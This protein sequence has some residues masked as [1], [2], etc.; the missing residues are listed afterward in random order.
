MAMPNPLPRSIAIVGGFW[1]TVFFLFSDEPLWLLVPAAGWSLGMALSGAIIGAAVVF[2]WKMLTLEA[3]DAMPPVRGM[4]ISIGTIPKQPSPPFYKDDFVVSWWRKLLP[5]K[6]ESIDLSE[7]IPDWENFAEQHPKHAALIQACAAM[8]LRSKLPAATVSGGHGGASLFQHSINVVRSILKLV[9][10]WRYEGHKNKNGEIVFPMI[11]SEKTHH[12]FECG[13]PLPVT[14]AF[15]HDIGKIACYKLQDD[16]SAKEVRGNHD[17]EGARLLRGIQELWNLPRE[18]A[19]ALIIAVGFYHHPGSLPISSWITDRMR[20][21]TELLSF[22]DIEAGIAEGRP[23][24]HAD[25]EVSEDIQHAE[26]LPYI[27]PE[28]Q[29]EDAARHE[30]QDEQIDQTTRGND[31]SIAQDEADLDDPRDLLISV[32][33]EPNRVNGKNSMKRVAFKYGKWLYVSEAKLRAS[34]AERTGDESFME[35]PGRDLHPW[36]QKLIFNLSL[37]NLIK[38]DSESDVND[39]RSAVFNTV[40]R[41]E[42]HPAREEKHVLVISSALSPSL[43]RLEDC[44]AAPEICGHPSDVSLDPF[45][46]K[47][48]IWA[49][50]ESAIRLERDSPT[51]IERVVEGR[52]YAFFDVATV[53]EEFPDSDIELRPENIALVQ[54]GASGK[55]YLRVSM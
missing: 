24:S 27:E 1:F 37:E 52:R 25:A 4:G 28:T 46:S 50:L 16:E 8:M 44:K 13:D 30:Y 11:D 3:R 53:R 33:L 6:P 17:T 10:T 32:L 18:D 43:A 47:D 19:I 23:A 7:H 2:V 22:A 40:S 55:W 9:P 26:P 48:P 14:A 42:G 36:T 12:A 5:A 51:F 15:L 45:S 39:P 54:G 20:S 38:F 41:V 29:E 34:I 21:L 49:A 35:L 31:F